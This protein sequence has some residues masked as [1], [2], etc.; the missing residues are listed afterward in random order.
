MAW[1]YRYALHNSHKN[2]QSIFAYGLPLQLVSDNGPQFFSTE[3]KE[4]LVHNSIKHLRSAHYH[5]A[6]NGLAECFV[7]SIKKALLACLS[8]IAVHCHRDWVTSYSCTVQHPMPP[9]RRHQVYYFSNV[10]WEPGWSCWGLIMKWMHIL[11][12]LLRK[13]IMIPVLKIN[14]SLLDRRWR[15][16]WFLF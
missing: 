16:S 14:I 12:R 6:T 2:L 7:Q 4:F 13:N 9:Q 1:S 15:I 11:A 5:P 10:H 3:F 8:N